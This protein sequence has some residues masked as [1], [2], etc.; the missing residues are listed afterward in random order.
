MAGCTVKQGEPASRVT[1]VKTQEIN[2]HQSLYIKDGSSHHDD[3]TLHF[4]A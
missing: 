2:Y 3:R 4:E 1:M